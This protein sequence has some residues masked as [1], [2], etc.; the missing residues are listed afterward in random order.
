M[1]L[2]LMLWPLRVSERLKLRGAVRSVLPGALREWID[3]VPELTRASPVYPDTAIPN[4][5][6]PIAVVHHGCVAE[7]LTPSE[8]RNTE[9]AL[10]AAGY[11]VAQLCAADRD[12]GQVFDQI[13]VEATVEI[14]VGP[15]DSFG[16]VRMRRGDSVVRRTIEG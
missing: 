16:G 15:G 3:L 12:H 2:R 7:V 14:N 1:R 4:S 6:G 5:S 9:R 8:N 11:Q 10:Q 13:G